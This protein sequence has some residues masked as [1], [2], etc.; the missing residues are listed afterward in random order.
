MADTDIEA[1]VQCSKEADYLK[2]PD[3]CAIIDAGSMMDRDWDVDEE[4]FRRQVTSD[5]K[6]Q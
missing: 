2:R 1:A 6:R 4:F 5:R 3:R